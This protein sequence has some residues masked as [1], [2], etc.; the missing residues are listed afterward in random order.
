M[1]AATENKQRIEKEEA[2]ARVAKIQADSL[3]DQK[4]ISADATSY[5]NHKLAEDNKNLLTPSYLEMRKIESFGC[6]NVIHYG[7]LPNFL[8]DHRVVETA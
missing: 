2:D 5:A 7:N 8:P 4:R 1:I 6:Q 3:A